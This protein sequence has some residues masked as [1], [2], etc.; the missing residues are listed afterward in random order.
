MKNS[1]KA[2]AVLAILGFAGTA[3]AQNTASCNPTANGTVIAPIGIGF[4]Q[5]LQFGN[6]LNAGPGTVTMTQ[7]GAV[8]SV[9]NMNPGLAAGP[10]TVPTFTATG[11]PT[12]T[13]AVVRGPMT[14]VVGG[15]N[16][17]WTSATMIAFDAV[18]PSSGTLTGGTATWTQGGILTIPALCPL[19]TYAGTW[20][21][22][23]NYN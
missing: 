21:V 12:F 6:V 13:F 19:G 22:A 15:G 10:Q 7:G 17:A 3:M 14:A 1:I 5:P 11:Q 20:N 16:L 4:D 9:A 2:L 23:V 18:G 8:Y